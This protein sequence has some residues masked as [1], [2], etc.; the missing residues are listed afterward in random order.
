MVGCGQGW[1]GVVGGGCRSLEIVNNDV[2]RCF[3]LVGDGASLVEMVGHGPVSGVVGCGWVR[4]GVVRWGRVG[5]RVVRGG[6]SRLEV[7][8]DRWKSL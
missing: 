4:L 7:D 3:E 6:W 5:S 2:I 1:S 8:V